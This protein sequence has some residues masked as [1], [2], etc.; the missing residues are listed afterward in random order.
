MPTLRP[1]RLL[2]QVLDSCFTERGEEGAGAAPLQ[3]LRIFRLAF[4]LKEVNAVIESQEHT[5]A[6]ARID[7]NV[8]ACMRYRHYLSKNFTLRQRVESMAGHIRYEAASYRPA[9]RIAVNFADGLA[10]WSRMVDGVHYGIRLVKAHDNLY[11]GQRSVVLCVGEQRICVMSFSYVDAAIFGLPSESLLFVTR[12]QSDAGSDAKALFVGTFKQNYPSYFCL[13]AVSGIAMANGMTRVAAVKPRAQVA[14]EPQR[15]AG[16]EWSYGTFWN[17]FHAADL[18]AQAVLLP[19]PLELR[20]VPDIKS[21][22][23]QR[24]RERRKHWAEV[25]DSAWAATSSMRLSDAAP[26]LPR[27]GAS[28]PS[29]HPADVRASERVG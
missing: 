25:R 15:A 5:G 21:K 13:A 29:P 22:H 23:R 16:F 1:L 24:A 17:T 7:A 27:P 8:L 20:P 2:R 26:G 11:E 9:Y 18:D 12:N 19:I 6:A 14:Y 3:R 28:V 4:F 10:L